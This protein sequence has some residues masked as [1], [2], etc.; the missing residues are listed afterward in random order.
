MYDNLFQYADTCDPLVNG[1]IK[2]FVESVFA[3]GDAS[4]I[5]GVHVQTTN[6]DQLAFYAIE[7]GLDSADTGLSS[8]KDFRSKAVEDLNTKLGG[9]GKVVYVPFKDT[10]PMEAL[11]RV[12]TPISSRELKRAVVFDAEFVR[13]G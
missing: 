13:S 2:T 5:V 7:Q 1:A 10:T 12:K 9:I 3:P 8:V 6:E 4:W 11:K